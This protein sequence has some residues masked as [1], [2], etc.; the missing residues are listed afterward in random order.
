MSVE[1]TGCCWEH[2]VA[3]AALMKMCVA[4]AA[5]AMIK[6]AA[7]GVENYPTRLLPWRRYLP[8][9]TAMALTEEPALADLC[10]SGRRKG[11]RMRQ[12]PT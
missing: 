2:T 5:S 7:G 9:K 4:A 6:A 12:Q 3:A 8:W 11:M 1:T 10:N